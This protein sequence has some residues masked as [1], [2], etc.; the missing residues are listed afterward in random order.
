MAKRGNPEVLRRVLRFLR[1][2]AGLSQTDFGACY[3]VDQTAVSEAERGNRAPSEE[4]QR[5]MARAQGIPWPVIVHLRRFVE[6]FLA[7]RVRRQGAGAGTAA[8][9]LERAVLEAVLLA[10]LPYLA[11]TAGAGRP[12]AGEVIAQAERAWTALRPLSPPERRRLLDV[13][14]RTARGWGLAVAACAASLRAAA[15]GAAAAREL[16][17]LALYVAERVP[18]TK[19]WRFRLRGFCLAHLAN[20]L[21]IANAFDEADAVFARAWELWRAGDD[22]GPLQLEEWRMLS[23]EASLRREQHRFAEALERL[24]RAL[25]AAAGDRAATVRLYLQKEHVSEQRGDPEGAVAVLAEAA[26]LLDG[27]GDPSLL[28]AHR[29]KTANNLAHLH[30]YPEA[31]ALLPGVQALAAQLGGELQGWRVLWLEARVLAGLGRKEEAAGKLEQVQAAF[32]RLQ[33]PYDAALA[34]LELAELWL[35]A[36][37]A[38]EVAELAVGLEWIF[39]A[40]G[41]AREALAALTLFTEAARRQA[42][43]AGLARQVVADLEQAR[44]ALPLPGNGTGRQP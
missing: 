10:T 11:E 27:L 16:A 3:G 12:T 34:A 44:R 17:E 7:A 6:A 26:P 8:E 13:A 4:E 35:E 15:D 39:K 23:L 32:T 1:F 9:G 25:E 2:D 33:L 31:A 38:A 37:R 30:R 28:F 36:G 5:R 40:Q 18:G 42:A 29:F 22:S 24:D 20:S 41:I 19:A 14:A 21:R 43:T